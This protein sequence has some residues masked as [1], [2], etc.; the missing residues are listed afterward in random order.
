VLGRLWLARV[1][2][3]VDLRSY[4]AGIFAMQA[5]ML[6]LIA[7]SP[8]APGLIG[9][10]L[11]YGFCLGQI[12]TLSPIVVRR[13]F[14][15]ASFGAI[16]SVAATVIALSSA[17]GPGLYGVLHDLAAGYGPV[18]GTAAAIELAAGA[19]ILAGRS[20]RPGQA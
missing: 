11:I 1:A 17:F 20:T 12:T 10:S 13:E 14:G 5:L 3:R 2:D 7:L 8:G 15:A 6:G 16:Y 9:G 18:L 4:T 19:T